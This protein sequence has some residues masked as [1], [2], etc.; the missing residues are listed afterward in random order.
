MK[1]KKLFFLVLV[2]MFT[3][4]IVAFS[5]NKLIL[6]NDYFL[7]H[8]VSI[9]LT[10]SMKPKLN[11]KDLVLIKKTNKVNIGDIVVYKNDDSEIIHRIVAKKGKYII[12]KGD[13]NNIDDAPINIEQVSGKY[14]CTIPLFGSIIFFFRSPLGI[15][16]STGVATFL[17]ITVLRKK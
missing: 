10:G 6:K 3:G 4:F 13:A 12:T 11:V 9:V 16:I 15:S 8:K 7:N 1:K 5:F 2:I 14:L 17:L